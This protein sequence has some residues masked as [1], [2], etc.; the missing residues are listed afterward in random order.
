LPLLFNFGL[1]PANGKVQEN[2]V[3]LKLNGTHQLPFCAADMKLLGDNIDIIKINTQTLIDAGKEDGLEVN[4]EKTKYILLSSP[5]CR[6][7]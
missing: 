4:T 7:L 3:G 1:E 5:E 6:S 2:Q